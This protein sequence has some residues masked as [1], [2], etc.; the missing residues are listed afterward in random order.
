[1]NLDR[2]VRLGLERRIKNQWYVLNTTIIDALQLHEMQD[3]ALQEQN[4]LLAKKVRL[5]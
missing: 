4:N 5:L 3:R 1:M 2:D